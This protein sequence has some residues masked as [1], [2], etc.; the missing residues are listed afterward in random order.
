MKRILVFFLILNAINLNL[1]AQSKKKYKEIKMT[2]RSETIM[3][4]ADK[5]WEIVGPGFQDAYKWSTAVDH[6][7]GSGAAQFEGATCSTRACDLNAKGFN[8]I[9]ETLTFYDANKQE[10]AYDVTE[11]NPG[12]VLKANNHWKVVEVG[13]NQSALEMT[14]DIHTKKFMGSLMGG[15]LKKNINQLMPGIFHDLQIYA[16]SGKIS[17]EKQE[18]IAALAAKN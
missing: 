16:E 9:K 17:E 4:S 12:F 6:S 11:G 18:R 14:I 8:K 3:V 7:T 1:M 2:K 5:L 15:M 13:P 10:L